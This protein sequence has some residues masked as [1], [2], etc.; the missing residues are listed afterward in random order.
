SW[1]LIEKDCRALSRSLPF[2]DET[3]WLGFLVSAIDWTA[4]D[5]PLPL[6]AFLRDELSRLRHL[7]L[8]NSYSFDRIEET[9]R[10][11][12]KWSDGADG[13]SLSFAWLKLVPNAWAGYGEIAI[14]DLNPA[15]AEVAGYPEAAIRRFDRF[16]RTSGPAILGLLVRA[17][18]NAFQNRGTHD[19]EY[20]PELIRASAV[21][22]PDGW[23]RGYQNYR[24]A[25]LGFLRKHEI[26]PREFVAACQVHP[27]YRIR[28]IAL[29]LENDK[30]LWLVWLACALSYQ[31]ERPTE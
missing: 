3:A 8:A 10:Q 12:Q 6:H 27:D 14:A 1:V 25:F 24:E 16:Q 2:H 22:L 15:V 17:L 19:A 31:C 21:N 13:L 11:S 23:H 9:D 28:E 26:H 29:E 4:W 18:D 30:S 5:R 7:E 20:P